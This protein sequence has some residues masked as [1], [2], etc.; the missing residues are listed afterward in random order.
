M[1]I[2]H[3]VLL[4]T[5]KQMFPFPK[6]VTP[7]R[8]LRDGRKVQ[9]NLCEELSEKQLTNYELSVFS[10]SELLELKR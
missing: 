8:F 10:I 5:E 1:N 3:Y 9:L 4:G 2:L 6:V 7:D